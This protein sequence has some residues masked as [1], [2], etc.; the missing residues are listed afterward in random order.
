MRFKK[1]RMEK[2]S[3]KRG[4]SPITH[5]QIEDRSIVVRFTE[6]KSYSYSYLK[7][8]QHHIERMKTLA[9]AGSGLCAYI[10]QNV[11]YEYD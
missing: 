9:K 7:A 2:Y 3:N 4:N 1:S 8:G 10:T 6:G 11:K 5:F